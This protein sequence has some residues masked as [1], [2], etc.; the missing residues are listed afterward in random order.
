MAIAV[1]KTKFPKASPKIIHYRDY[2][3]FDL[4]AFRYELKKQMKDVS[5]YLQFENKFLDLLDIQAPKKK[6][7]V[8]ETIM[9]KK[10]I[11][12]VQIT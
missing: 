4:K 8:N 5:D 1:L 12:K 11:F 10:Q 2:K 3:N 7:T 9:L 6:K